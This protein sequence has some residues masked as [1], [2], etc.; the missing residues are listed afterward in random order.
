VEHLGIVSVLHSQTICITQTLIVVLQHRFCTNSVRENF[1]Q[2]PNRDDVQYGR[3][4]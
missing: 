1:I 4:V 2:S 3:H